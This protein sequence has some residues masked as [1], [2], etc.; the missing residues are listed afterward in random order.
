[1]KASPM[2]FIGQFQSNWISI[3]KPHHSLWQHPESTLQGGKK[4]HC[5][6]THH[7]RMWVTCLIWWWWVRKMGDPALHERESLLPKHL[8]PSRG[9]TPIIFRHIALDGTTVRRNRAVRLQ[10]S[11]VKLAVIQLRKQQLSVPGGADQLPHS[12]WFP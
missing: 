3:R 5:G 10:L 4:Q 12:R 7:R 1:M 8:L 6:R 2:E 11:S 9:N